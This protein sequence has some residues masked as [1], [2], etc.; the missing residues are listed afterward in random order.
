[1]LD[2]RTQSNPIVRLSSINETFDLVRVV[3]SI[4]S[5][6]V[7]EKSLFQLS[8]WWSFGNFHRLVCDRK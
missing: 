4:V 6:L 3:S 1:M 8:Q 2:C 5:R 7:V